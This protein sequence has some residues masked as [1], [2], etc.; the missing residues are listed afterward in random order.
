MSV[1]PNIVA[2]LYIWLKTTRAKCETNNKLTVK[3]C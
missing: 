2:V 1:I 3:S